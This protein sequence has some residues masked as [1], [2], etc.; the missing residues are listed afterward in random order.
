VIK[1]EETPDR[2]TGKWQ[3]NSLYSLLTLI[4]LERHSHQ[5]AA[6]RVKFPKTVMAACRVTN[7]DK[8]L[9]LS[10]KCHVQAHIA[11]IKAGNI[12]QDNIRHDSIATDFAISPD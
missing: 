4:L 6:Q 3:I 7:Q 8:A 11:P 12:P 10:K 2:E 1:P 9:I 5:P